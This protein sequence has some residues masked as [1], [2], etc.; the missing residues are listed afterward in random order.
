MQ[1]Y[2]ILEE[3]GRNHYATVYEAHDCTFDRPVAVMQFKESLLLDPER[4]RQI[5]DGVKTMSQAADKHVAPVYDLDEDKGWMVMKM[6]CSHLGERVAQA[7]VDVSDV[8]SLLNQV[9][10]SLR[11]IHEAGMAH[12]DICPNNLLF[13]DDG[14]IMLSFSPG[15]YLGGTVPKRIDQKYSAPE[16]LNPEAFGD[17]GAPTD[18]YLLG[19]TALELLAGP[20]FNSFFKGTEGG[21]VEMAWMRY[22]GD[23]SL[24]LPL[25]EEI[26]PN[27]PSALAD[28]IDRMLQKPVADRYQTADEALHDLNRHGSLRFAATPNISLPEAE[29]ETPQPATDASLALEAVDENE[30]PSPGHSR[31][32]SSAKKPRAAA[33]QA[34]QS[35]S[36]ESEPVPRTAKP[37]KQPDGKK[38]NKL[39]ESAQYA[40]IFACLLGVFYF[41]IPGNEADEQPTGATTQHTVTIESTPAGADVALFRLDKE[42][43]SK[44]VDGA[45]ARTPLEI[46]LQPGKY[47]VELTRDRKRG[48]REFEITDKTKDGEVVHLTLREPESDS[49]PRTY[50]VTFSVQ[51]A[52][53]SLKL[54]HLENNPASG[55]TVPTEVPLPQTKTDPAP[56]PDSSDTPVFDPLDP[57]SRRRANVSAKLKSGRYRIDAKLKGYKPASRTFTVVNQSMQIALTLDR[58]PPKTGTVRITIACR[59][60]TTKLTLDGKPVELDENGTASV[61]RPADYEQ[62]TV[63][64]S[65]GKHYQSVKDRRVTASELASDD[66]TL[67]V[68][69]YPYLKVTPSGANVTVDGRTL[70]LNS[71]SAAL[72]AIDEQTKKF[73]LRISA[74]EQFKTYDQTV[75]LA[76]LAMTDFKITLKEDPVYFFKLG[77]AAL[78]KRQYDTAR[79]HFQKAVLLDE[80]YA[81]AYNG[82]GLAFHGLKN[83]SAAVD[84]FNKAIEL[85]PEYAKA[86]LNRAESHRL[87]A[88][89]SADK[90]TS[91]MAAASDYLTALKYDPSLA[92]Q[93]EVGL[94]AVYPKIRKSFADDNKFAEGIRYFSNATDATANAGKRVQAS[95][96]LQRGR[97]FLVDSQFENAVSD[98][99]TA[100]GLNETDPAIYW[101][102]AQAHIQ[103]AI[104]PERQPIDDLTKSIR[105]LYLTNRYE[106]RRDIRPNTNYP[107]Y[108]A[109]VIGLLAVVYHFRGRIYLQQADRRMTVTGAQNGL[110]LQR[111]ISRQKNESPALAE[112]T[113]Y[114]GHQLCVFDQTRAVD[115]FEAVIG[116][117]FSSTD[118]IAELLSQS[119][120]YRA[121]A[122]AAMDDTTSA[123][124]DY[125]AALKYNPKSWHALGGRGMLHTRQARQF[126]SNQKYAAML[127]SMA[128]AKTDLDAAIKAS[129]AR[130]EAITK[131]MARQNGRPK[132]SAERQLR[133][134][135]HW[136]WRYAYHRGVVHEMD[137]QHTEAIDASDR[138]TKL[139]AASGGIRSDAEAAMLINLFDIQAEA[140]MHRAK[141][142]EKTGNT[143]AAKR[144][145]DRRKDILKRRSKVLEQPTAPTVPEVNVRSKDLKPSAAPPAPAQ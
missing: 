48:T 83:D 141:E 52:A 94:L 96:Y 35:A 13:N 64:A 66:N 128:S 87:V 16:L 34:E 33:A 30:P 130:A 95:A 57:R 63:G 108:S 113:T 15:L 8:A 4:A 62:I 58:L 77:Q 32:A 56:N 2:E 49:S 59:P 70:R 133:N 140:L 134:L 60:P 45:N 14:Q 76:D 139:L 93:T 10:K 46:K 107:S 120:S 92:K 110:Y 91:Y 21:A 131:S 73:R 44:Q 5:W 124:R 71:E 22:H 29:G 27:L 132:A 105:D 3:L 119:L 74:G 101:G 12:G 135:N 86:Y 116:D 97:L 9:L 50:P 51:P 1:R 41:L 47:R 36:G 65:N 28:I 129:D 126:L 89:K 100:A 67:V 144:D 114:T 25:A 102:R 80:Q 72:L 81:E 98:F 42:G 24:E 61:E 123:L 31:R 138:A 127:K 55:K 53:A 90:R 40:V 43:H 26:V 145:N 78:E 109:R 88:G 18:I 85:R 69:L 117:K 106:F 103:L 23:P 20:Q 112:Q 75:T 6:L 137:K 142:R 19:F 17:A 11:S 121:T 99:N 82:Q 136:R 122:L 38:K 37:P 118:P 115:L 125:D 54:V 111:E 84:R 79:Q 104:V 68:T 39:V 7:P 143:A